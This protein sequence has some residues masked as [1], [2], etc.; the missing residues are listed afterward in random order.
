M[1]YCKYCGEELDVLD[2]MRF[3][4]YC[5]GELEPPMTHTQP[6]PII[7]QAQIIRCP[8]CYKVRPPSA[9][10]CQQCGTDLIEWP[11]KK[12]KQKTDLILAII[13][14]VG[15]VLFAFAVCI[16]WKIDT[17]ALIAS[18]S[19]V[20]LVVGLLMAWAIPRLEKGKVL[21]KCPRCAETIK[22]KAVKCKHCGSD[23]GEKK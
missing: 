3:C 1:A 17:E 5:G 21:Q 9:T 6:E 11:K 13:G 2:G 7:P 14:S 22:V 4:K 8:V 16:A 18:V 23:L 10:H 12:R 20:A 15:A 19:C